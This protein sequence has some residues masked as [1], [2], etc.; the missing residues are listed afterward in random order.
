MTA[1]S[2]APAFSDMHRSATPLQAGMLFNALANPASG[3]DIQQVAIT[4][5][6]ALDVERFTKAWQDLIL[7]HAI[8]RTSFAWE[9]L[10]TPACVVHDDTA[11]PIEQHDWSNLD[12]AMQEKAKAALMR[13][14]RVK[15]FAMDGPSLMRLT[16]AREADDR[17]WVL[18]TFHHAILD[19]RSF[20]LV[21]ER[22]LALY[23]GVVSSLTPRGLAFD[24]Y[25]GALAA[26]DQAPAKEAWQKRLAP[27]ESP[28]ID[29][30][31]LSSHRAGR[32]CSRCFGD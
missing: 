12:Q 18:W 9:G 17:W 2:I 32:G 3:V 29:R 14:E 22:L 4:L 25:A 30:H 19:G 31:S 15:G 7:N 6:E 21:L 24:D 26:I 13:A 20:P 8:L 5:E 10:S 11:M 1:T 28:D 23:D 16:I 27:L